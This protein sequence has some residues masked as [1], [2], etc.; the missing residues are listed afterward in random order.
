MIVYF[1]N[2]GSYGEG[3]VKRPILVNEK[4]IGFIHEVTEELVTCYL[5]DRFVH[6]EI[7]AINAFSKE[8]DIRAI[9]IEV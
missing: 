8:Q 3:A 9:S 1:E 4:P 6:K 7:F 2:D 5:F